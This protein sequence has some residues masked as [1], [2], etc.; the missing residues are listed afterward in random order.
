MKLIGL[1]TLFLVGLNSWG[2]QTAT[3]NTTKNVSTKEVKSF[4]EYCIQH[5]A[6][7]IELPEG[8][9]NSYP[10][11]GNVDMP[12]VANPTY[13]DFGVA[14]KDEATQYFTVSNTNKLLKVESLYRLRLQYALTLQKL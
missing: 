8:K 7:I 11:E 6:T 4:E 12:A 3:V 5:A 9:G 1:F 13:L 10:V 2:Q 14:I